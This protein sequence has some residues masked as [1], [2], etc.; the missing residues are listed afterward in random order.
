MLF[1]SDEKNQNKGEKVKAKNL[2]IT[3]MSEGEIFRA[4]A[5][6]LELS[7]SQ[8]IQT[9]KLNGSTGPVKVLLP[10]RGVSQ[11]DSEGN[12]FWWPEADG[13]LFDA[14]KSNLRPGIE[15]LELDTNVNDPAFADRAADELLGMLGR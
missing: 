12:P 13:A 1:V 4:P 2:D 8:S 10:L 9:A 3:P 7:S 15:V 5:E 6:S 14:L 11:L